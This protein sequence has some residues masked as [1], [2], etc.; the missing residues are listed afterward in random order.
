MTVGDLFSKATLQVL[1]WRIAVAW[2]ILFSFNSL[3]TATIA[4]LTGTKWNTLDAQAHFLIVC[5]ILANWTGT[6]MAFV[7]KAAS[8]VKNE[9]ENVNSTVTKTTSD[10][11]IN[12]TITGQNLPLP[13]MVLPPTVSST[14]NSPVS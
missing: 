3:L 7:S 4:A 14:T 2:F 1:G 5:A 12:Q 13:A 9:L 6:I 8:K 11:H 10:T